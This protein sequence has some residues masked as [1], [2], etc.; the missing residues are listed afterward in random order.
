[1]E[2]GWPQSAENLRVVSV[3]RRR[4]VKPCTKA[5]F[6]WHSAARSTESPVLLS[7]TP[8]ASAPTAL[9]WGS[10]PGTSLWRSQFLLHCIQ[11]T[12]RPWRLRPLRSDSPLFRPFK[13]W[14]DD[15]SFTSP[16][17]AYLGGGLQ[18]SPALGRWNALSGKL[19]TPSIIPC[20]SAGLHSPGLV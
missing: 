19:S 6:P 20:G 9:T 18:D 17:P 8:H 10:K 13:G 14:L 5:L 7:L 4:G 16:C 2:T 11:I 15:W 1:M 12:A 3:S